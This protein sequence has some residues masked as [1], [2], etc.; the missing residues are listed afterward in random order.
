MAF[1]TPAILWPSMRGGRSAM[2]VLPS[3][4]GGAWRLA[5]AVWAAATLTTWLALPVPPSRLTPDGCESVNL[6]DRE[7]WDVLK[8]NPPEGRPGPATFHLWDLAA[9]RQVATWP[10]PPEG[11]L[12]LGVSPDG[13]RVVVSPKNLPPRT[14]LLDPASGTRR[15]LPFPPRSTFRFTA[16]GRH[17]LVSAF[18]EYRTVVWNRAAERAAAAIP[19][20]VVWRLAADGRWLSRERTPEGAPD[21]FRVRAAGTGAELARYA[22]P[23]HGFEVPEFT[24]DGRHL[25]LQ[26]R[27]A[28]HVIDA[29]TGRVVVTCPSRNLT[30]LP[31]EPVAVAVDLSPGDPGAM[32]LTRWSLDTGEQLGREVRPTPAT[33][34]ENVLVVR[35]DGGEVTLFDEHGLRFAWA[36]RLSWVPY[37]AALCQSYGFTTVSA[38][39]GEVVRRARMPGADRSGFKLVGG[40]R[41]FRCDSPQAE[42]WDLHPRRPPWWWLAPLAVLWGLPLAVAAFWRSRQLPA[43]GRLAAT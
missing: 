19:D 41:V 10:E 23:A 4:P 39:T 5:A 35:A 36:K 34:A 11:E 28:C 14:A 31:G 27:Q 26:S 38:R 33:S 12:C 25:V 9:C 2:G 3:T 15:P 6:V 1:M 21:E 37:V 16:D 13:S 29:A 8:Q 24:P 17:M 43:A 42:L 7:R 20:S 40:G 22:R 18:P 30:V 32:T